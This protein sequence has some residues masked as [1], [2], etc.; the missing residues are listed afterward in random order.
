VTVEPDNTVV[1]RS[2]GK[3]LSF[4]AHRDMRIRIEDNQVI[5]ERPTDTKQHK[6]LHGTTRALIAN[7]VE[8]VRNG[9]MRA[10]ELRGLGY[11]AQMRG[12]AVVLQVGLSHEVVYEPPPDVV[13]EVE[14]R[15]PTP[16]QYL[17]AI[18]TVRG[19]DRQK[20]GQVAA[21]IRRIRPVEPYKG[22]GLRYREEHV[23]LKQGKTGRVAK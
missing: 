10:L 11:R 6:A 5:V 4:R 15:N 21:E 2:D 22:K 17:A 14:P 1:V 23:R 3:E 20:V 7:M 13:V 18:I 19:I 9:F 12:R 16:P 8:G